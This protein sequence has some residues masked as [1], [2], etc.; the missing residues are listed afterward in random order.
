MS[1]R[2]TRC[3]ECGGLVGSLNED[4]AGE[5]CPSCAQRLLET[6]PGVFHRPW[7]QPWPAKTEASAS[8]EL[9]DLEELDEIDDA[10]GQ[11]PFRGV[12]GEDPF[13]EPDLPA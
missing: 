1:G 8:D 6:L 5:P 7:M 12:H 11:S 4:E 13:T 9:D 3:I 10:E 2:P